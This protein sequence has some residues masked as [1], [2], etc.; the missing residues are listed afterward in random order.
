MPAIN[1]QRRVSKW[2]ALWLV[3]PLAIF[4]HPAFSGAS[5]TSQ[6]GNST[7]ADAWGPAAASQAQFF[8]TKLQRIVRAKDKGQFA[9]LLH[10][11]VRVLDGNH[12]YDIPSSSVFI[13]KYSSVITPAVKNAIL[14]QSGS[15]LFANG[16]GIMIGRGQVWFQRESGWDMKITSINLRAPTKHD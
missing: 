6:C 5:D 4:V 9:S 7:V 14:E 13:R 8:L 12:S 2:G 11:P 10:Y 1:K 3:L 16:D 15:C